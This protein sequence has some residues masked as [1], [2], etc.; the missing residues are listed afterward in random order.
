MAAPVN[1][2]PFDNLQGGP[3]LEVLAVNLHAGIKKLN[4]KNVPSQEDFA[5]AI[6][7]VSIEDTIRGSSSVTITIYDREWEFS[8]SGWFDCDANG[9]LDPIDLRYGTD[10]SGDPQWWRITQ[11]N[12]KKNYTIDLVFME[13]AAVYMMAH[14][15]PYKVSRSRRTRAQ[16]IKS[17]FDKVRAGGGIRF[18][19]K[20]LD[21]DQ[22]IDNKDQEKQQKKDAKDRA[23]EKS[24]GINSSEV[25]K[26]KG[27]KATP[28]QLTNLEDAL[29]EAYKLNAPELAVLSMVC[30]GI[31]ESGWKEIMNTAGSGYGGVLQGDVS[32][33]YH[34]F[35]KTDTVPQAHYF[36]IG[37]KGYQGGGAIHLA[38][39]HPDWGPGLIAVTVEG[40][41]SNFGSDADA[42]RFYGQYV[43]EAKAIIEA[44]G[45]GSFGGTTYTK[46]YNFEIGTPDDP[47]EDFW[48][49]T[50]RL[51]EVVNW[52]L[53]LDGDTAY[54]DP[55]TTLIRQKPVRILTVYDDDLLDWDGTW[56]AR[57]VATGVDMQLICGP[58]DY[59]AGQVLKFV[60]SEFGAL[61]S[62]STAKL[63]GR[64]LVESITRQR[65]DIFSR[66]TLIQPHN[67]DP[68]PA[69]EAAERAS[70]LANDTA[71]V[72]GTPKE[73]I[74]TIVLPI[75][76][77][78]GIQIT[79]NQVE[80]ANA[81]HGPT[82]TGGRSD[83]QG[84]PAVA[85]AA[86]ISNGV[87]TP[88]EAAL[89][90][91]LAKRFNI[92]YVGTRTT[93]G[94]FENSPADQK[95]TGYRY[96][97]IHNTMEGGNHYNH[98]H[99]GVKKVGVGSASSPSERPAGGT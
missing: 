39:A 36:M 57:K 11:A 66:F 26:I 27:V 71:D 51:A 96:Q 64:W 34:Y 94:L 81:R 20:D 23:K 45:G 65:A 91:A 12:P 97:L 49:G 35:K 3:D 14:K 59:R 28:E 24:P 25:L 58:F 92:P 2:D 82:V 73:I 67:P 50:Q 99:F 53:F 62:G 31:G 70:K 86:D 38:N 74:D 15:G 8:K 77:E 72:K 40:S 44:Y 90:V 30:S 95:R 32:A 46:Q 89:C 88:E 54:Y 9:K 63:P 69:S 33:R 10:S 7:D 5:D 85:W 80:A 78:N 48:D 17:C 16:F 83:H 55:E 98:V 22:P 76:R 13:R 6:L 21:K 87:S 93:G 1:I 79:A 29:G 19:S 37:G 75:A 84:P 4:K 42:E 18:V 56:D 61:S 52:P 60:G 43:D 41:R 47:H 68:E